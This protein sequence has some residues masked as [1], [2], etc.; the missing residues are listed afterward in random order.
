MSKEAKVLLV[1]MPNVNL[2]RERDGRNLAP[3]VP[4]APNGSKQY[5]ATS[6]QGR[7]EVGIVDLK[8]TEKLEEDGSIS[9]L[10]VV[11]EEYGQLDWE[12]DGVTKVRWGNR[13]FNE[14]LEKA[15]DE[16]ASTNGVVGFTANFLKERGLIIEATR[17]VIDISNG[18]ARVVV[19]GRD[20]FAEPFPYLIAGADAV[21]KNMD[22][23]ANQA[24]VEYITGQK[25]SRP[26]TKFDVVFNPQKIF[27]PYEERLDS[28]LVSQMELIPSRRVVQSTMGTQHWENPLPEHL[29]KLG[30][31]KKIWKQDNESKF[32]SPCDETCDFCTVPLLGRPDLDNL[33]F[34]LEG[35]LDYVRGLKRAGVRTISFIDD[36]LLLDVLYPGGEKMLLDFFGELRKEGLAWVIGNGVQI[37]K[38]TLSRGISEHAAAT[39]PYYKHRIE[40]LRNAGERVEPGNYEL[41]ESLVK[42]V[43]G[44]E[45]DAIGWDG[46]KGVGCVAV[47]WPGEDPTGGE[48]AKGMRKL[49]GAS[50]QVNA[51]REIFRISGM[52]RGSYGMIYGRHDQTAE[53]M[54][55]NTDA[56]L[57]IKRAL[58]VDNPNIEF[59]V[60]PFALIPATGTNAAYKTWRGLE[61]MGVAS[62]Y[63]ENPEL[64]GN[65]WAPKPTKLLTVRA[66]REAQEDAFTR[67]NSDIELDKPWHGME[68]KV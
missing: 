50:D 55:A 1:E 41:N 15:A 28:N 5:T 57:E 58:L 26:L 68:D 21:V 65:F 35:S 19:G 62:L 7:F 38:F 49:L 14:A 32:K 8:R 66:I 46:T 36:Q 39:D 42:A 13:N 64:A 24:I 48:K 30:A 60:T 18:R 63:S 67:L 17:K 37:K 31:F 2:V 20:A 54:M 59:I 25:V 29:N 11:E 12:G 3:N 51:L 6:L 27:L 22:G 40:Q 9:K 33:R 16:A 10:P 34:D 45:S 52:T 47:Y 43:C 4:N 23:D 56:A 44:W 53:H 61:E